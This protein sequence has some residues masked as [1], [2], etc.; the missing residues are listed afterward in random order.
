M[1]VKSL[2]VLTGKSKQG[3]HGF[4]TNWLMRYQISHNNLT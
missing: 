4:Q 1:I 2:L 3:V